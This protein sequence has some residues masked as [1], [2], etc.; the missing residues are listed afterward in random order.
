MFDSL[1]AQLGA[2]I[3]R[4]RGT[5]A[6]SEDNISDI[7]REIRLALLAADVHLD[8]ARELVARVREKAV[9]EAV[10]K[11]LSPEQQFV[12]IVHDELIAILGE[13]GE[14]PLPATPPA[15]WMMVGLQG[16]GKTTSAAKLARWYRAERKRK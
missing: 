3:R 11:S 14:L 16:S 1:Q 15:V 13:A 7:T 9:G 2:A 8:V 4:L 10:L 5:G 6:I 12:K